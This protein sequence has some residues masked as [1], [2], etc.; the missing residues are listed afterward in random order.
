MKSTLYKFSAKPIAVVLVRAFGRTLG[1]AFIAALPFLSVAIAARAAEVPLAK[2]PVTVKDSGLTDRIFYE[3]LISEIAGQRGRS[4]LALRGLIG[5]AQRTRD[6]RVARRAVEIAFQARQM[7]AA[8]EATTFWLELDPSSSVARQAIGGVIGNQTTL[9]LAKADLARLLAQPGRA[10]GVL[11]QLPLLLSR[12][13]DKSAVSGA[14]DALVA[15]YLQ[16]PEAHY[17]I[18]QSR[19]IA[20]D[21]KAALEAI[22][23]AEAR[24]APWSQAAILKAQILR[25]FS[26]ESANKHLK[27]FLRKYPGETEARLA[28]ARLLA[29]QK[30]YLQAREEFRLA[31]KAA[32]DDVEIP[33]AVGLISQQIEDYADAEMQFKRVLELKPVESSPVYFNLGAIATARKAPEAA[34]DWYSKV[35][36][37]EYFVTAQLK[38]ATLLARRDGMAAGRKFMQEA[39]ALQADAPETRIQLILAEAQLLREA[40]AFTEAFDALSEA[41]EKNPGTADLF[42]DR[43]MVAEKIDKIDMVEADLRRVIELRPEHAHAY[44]ALGYTLA[45]R[46]QRLDEAYE[47]IQK[48]V[49]LAPNDAFIQDSLGWV[50]FRR[51]RIDDA[52]ATLKQAYQARPDAEIAA[53]LGEVLWAKGE[54]AEALALWQAA[55]RESPEN[56]MLKSVISKFK[57]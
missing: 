14:V 4:G 3:Y 43:A 8:L 18:A 41:I 16:L 1:R 5:L 23:V 57:P 36:G 37:G 47:L 11:L 45:E 20:K 17:A 27:D 34:I 24:R 50:H 52:I 22:N 10:A 25:E 38:I 2:D 6:P 7:D 42:Y 55:L 19:L 40:K 48:A 33:Y 54:Q 12:F 32:P 53:H 26:E 28:F 9:A 13:P 35:K 15:P 46:N 49:S 39:Q 56:E 51:G 31:M 29:S 30:G 21:A 44:N